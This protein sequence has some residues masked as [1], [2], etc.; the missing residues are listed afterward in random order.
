MF[1]SLTQTRGKEKAVCIHVAIVAV[2]IQGIAPEL[3]YLLW[4]FIEIWL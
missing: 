2:Q 3:F 1:S 4:F